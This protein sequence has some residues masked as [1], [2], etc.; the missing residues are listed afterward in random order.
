MN[1]R[2]PVAFLNIVKGISIT[3]IAIT[4]VLLRHNLKKKNNNTSPERPM[5]LNIFA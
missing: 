3:S 4:K 5:D 1:K 2:S